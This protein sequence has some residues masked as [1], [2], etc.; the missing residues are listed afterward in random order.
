MWLNCKVIKNVATPPFVHQPPFWGL[1]SLS[2]K[3][4]WTPLVTQFLEGPTPCPSFN[5][6]GGGPINYQ[7]SLGQ[8]Y[9]WSLWRDGCL[10]EVVFKTISTVYAEN[11][12]Q[13]MGL[14]EIMFTAAT[15]LLLDKGEIGESKDHKTHKKI[16]LGSVL[17]SGEGR[18][19]LLPQS[20]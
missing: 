19:N 8:T 6:G 1:S 16:M 14:N 7:I 10:I 13:T 17:A 9:E 3:K 12:L 18:R 4:C 5:K 2:S 11:L 15:L 20:F